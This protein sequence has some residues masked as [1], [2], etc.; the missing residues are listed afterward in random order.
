MDHPP[1]DFTNWSTTCIDLVNHFLDTHLPASDSEPS[2]LHEAMRYA[3]L[4]SGK[5][6]RPLLCFASGFIT[7]AKTE[8][9]CVAASAI[10]LIHAY[11]L[12]HDDMPAMD[13]DVLRRGQPTCHVKYGEAIALLAGDTLQTLA[14]QWLSESSN[15]PEKQLYLIRLLSQASGSMGMG[16]GQAIDLLHVNQAMNLSQLETMH[17]MK[18]GALIEASILM[19]A[20][21]GHPPQPDQHDK[22]RQI[23]QNLGLIFQIK[24]DLLDI[25]SDSATLGKTAGKDAARNKPTYVSIMGIAK[26]ERLLEQLASET[27]LLIKQLGD[28]AHYLMQLSQ[29]FVHRQH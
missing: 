28:S 8:D 5:R 14:F 21:C 12:V 1:L 27:Y 20:Y 16:G 4:G 26:A 11:S 13:N 24:D 2:V 9:L 15:H 3:A 18:T 22:L 17:K 25:Q 23:G 6:I 29:L 10:E 7:Q 19:G